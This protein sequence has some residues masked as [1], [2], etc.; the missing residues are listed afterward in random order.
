MCD[1]YFWEW[2]EH[3][4]SSLYSCN[5]WHLNGMLNI[6]LEIFPKK[7]HLTEK[8]IQNTWETIVIL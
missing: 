3:S 1:Q 6:S 5:V 4:N 7:T 2:N 8:D